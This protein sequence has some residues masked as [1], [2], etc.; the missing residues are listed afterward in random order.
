[1]GIDVKI[2]MREIRDYMNR[3]A[4]K[5]QARVIAILHNVG[6][7]T[8]NKIRTK[9]ISAWNDRTGNLRSS[10][11]YI[12]CIDGKP[13][14]ISPFEKVVGP[15]PQTPGEPSGDQEGRAYAKR[16]ASLYPSGIALIVVAGMNYASYVEKRDNKVVLA[17]AELEA[18]AM[19]KRLL[20][21]L[22]KK[23]SEK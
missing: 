10:I 19:V 12:I 22:N 3:E 20:D 6:Q 8:V 5:N 13:V 9:H 4:Q 1:M 21:K 15:E 16:L 23:L 17:Q 14:E 2:N 7:D 11:G 18:P